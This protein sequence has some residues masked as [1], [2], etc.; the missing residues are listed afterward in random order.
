MIALDPYCIWFSDNSDQY[1]KKINAI[2]ELKDFFEKR[3]LNSKVVFNLKILVK[4][5]EYYPFSN[6]AFCKN[7]NYFYYLLTDL[8]QNMINIDSS[9]VESDVV[10]LNDFYSE[11]PNDVVEL[12]K[13]FL[14]H[15]DVDKILTGNCI[16]LSVRSDESLTI[17]KNDVLQKELRRYS[18]ELSE[19]FLPFFKPSPKHDSNQTNGVKGTPLSK[20][21]ERDCYALIDSAIKI[22]EESNS[23]IAYNPRTKNIIKFPQTLGYEYH[24]FPISR[25][26]FDQKISPFLCKEERRLFPD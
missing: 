5:N 14:L 10:F 4:L 15:D 9:F 22:K 21:D 13:N 6:A 17:Q 19:S 11:M 1:L 12:I 16:E 25:N 26:E 24:A 18:Y 7:Y 23:L 20:E 8:V 2:S 3:K